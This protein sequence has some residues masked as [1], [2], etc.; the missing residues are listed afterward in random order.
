M[1][2]EADVQAQSTILSWPSRLAVSRIRLLLTIPGDPVSKQRPRFSGKRAYTPAET[3]AAEESIKWH[4]IESHRALLPDA[5]SSF[6]VRLQFFTKNYQRRDLDNMSKLI[7]D[8]CNGMVWKDDAQVHE[9]TAR[10]VRADPNPRT[11]IAIYLLGKLAHPMIP[12]GICGKRFQTYPSWPTRGYCSIKCSTIAQRKGQ[13]YTCDQC[14]AKFYRADWATKRRSKNI[15]CS[16]VCKIAYGVVDLV[17]GGCGETFKRQRSL[18]NRGGSNSYCSEKCLAD[19]A[20]VRRAKAA[21]GICARC[22]GTTSKKTYQRCRACA[23]ELG[24]YHF[25]GAKPSKGEGIK[26]DA[27]VRYGVIAD[28]SSEVIDL[29]IRAAVEPK[30]T[31]TR[32]VVTEIVEELDER[33][34]QDSV[35]G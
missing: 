11:E 31:E 17:C 5:D 26:E 10:L 32:I 3:R 12:C 18:A 27:L 21:R 14:G 23:I 4:I 2:L 22:G 30:T 6:G 29:S 13:E 25:G 33:E 24:V 16:M 7:F 28:D 8:A 1:T 19:V 15:F 34:Q 35:D 9:L 20:R